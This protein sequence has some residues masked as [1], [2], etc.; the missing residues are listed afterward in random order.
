MIDY[1]PVGCRIVLS[2]HD[3]LLRIGSGDARDWWLRTAGHLYL[4]LRVSLLGGYFVPG[5]AN[6][7]FIWHLCR[8]LVLL[9]FFFVVRVFSMV[10]GTGID[11][12]ELGVH[13]SLMSHSVLTRQK[14]WCRAVDLR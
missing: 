7:T 10:R 13:A 6:T 14:E 8:H 3:L 4:L 2:Q 5:L 1:S 12:A 11:E 9:F